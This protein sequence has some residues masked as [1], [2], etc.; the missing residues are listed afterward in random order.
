[1]M[2]APPARTPPTAYIVEAQDGIK[3]EEKRLE[4]LKKQQEREAA[5][6]AK[7]AARRRQ[8]AA[9]RAGASAAPARR[10]SR[11]ARPRRRAAPRPWRFRRRACRLAL[12]GW[13]ADPDGCA[14][15]APLPARAASPRP[16]PNRGSWPMSTGTADPFSCSA[17]PPGL[18]M[19]ALQ[20]ARRTRKQRLRPPSA[21]APR[22]RR[23]P[24]VKVEKRR[25]RQKSLPNHRRDHES[26]ERS[27]SPRP[28]SSIKS[29]PSTTTGKS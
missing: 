2:G 21:T 29:R 24:K 15:P 9:R 20:A 14:A 8:E 12:L 5:R 17:S 18:A 6:A 4:R 7:K 16:P 27:K 13:R 19:L 3:K 11:P 28:S 25:G 1:M 26:R 10:R 23:Q 22:G